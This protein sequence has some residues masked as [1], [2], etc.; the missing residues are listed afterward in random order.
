MVTDWR[1]TLSD[2]ENQTYLILKEKLVLERT[3]KKK[4]VT[5]QCQDVD[6][7]LS[8]DIAV[9]K[10]KNVKIVKK[11]MT[12]EDDDLEV[13]GDK[14]L[15]K[16]RSIGLT[17]VK[18]SEI[19]CDD[20]KTILKTKMKVTPVKQKIKCSEE[21]PH[22]KEYSEYAEHVELALREVHGSKNRPRTEND[23]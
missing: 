14:C 3:H 13:V 16:A 19:V 20:K 17:S 21:L 8:K 18:S 4:E 9:T 7:S 5:G 2:S 12:T 6:H 1:M 15:T 11:K 10:N 22:G 23:T